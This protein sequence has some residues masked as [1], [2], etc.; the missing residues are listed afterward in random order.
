[1]KEN[2]QSVFK[3]NQHPMLENGIVLEVVRTYPTWR[4]RIK[5]L[6]N[7]LNLV[8]DHNLKYL[9]KGIK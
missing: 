3:T 5:V 6:F 1:M 4:M 8:N 9:G 2:E 7:G